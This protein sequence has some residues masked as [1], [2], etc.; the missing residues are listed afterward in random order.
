MTNVTNSDEWSDDE[1]NDDDSAGG[2]AVE[3]AKPKL[4]KP[5]MYRVIINNDDYTPMEFVVHVLENFFTM[6]RAK[7]T[8]VMMDV[9]NSG[10]GVCG[11]FT[12]DTA[13]TKTLQVNDYSKKHNHP[14]MC[15]MEV[16]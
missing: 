4:K 2:T 5:R 7:A 8:R 12:R 3:T 15:S 11:L 10:K 14:L 1:I 6:D 16:E 9:H 13:E